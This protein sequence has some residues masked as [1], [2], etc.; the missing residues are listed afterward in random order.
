MQPSQ[1]CLALLLG[2]A[3]PS[4]FFAEDLANEQ[5]PSAAAKHNSVLLF[6][7][8]WLNKRLST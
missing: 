3:L 8:N 4:A 6:S 7:V 2:F 1:F 5:L